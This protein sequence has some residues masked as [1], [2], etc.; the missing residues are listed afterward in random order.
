MKIVEIINGEERFWAETDMKITFACS[1]TPVVFVEEI[2]DDGEEP[3][4]GYVNKSQIK[5]L[6]ALQI[7]NVQRWRSGKLIGE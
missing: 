2:R 1:A 7:H 6:D 3:W 5:F 4:S